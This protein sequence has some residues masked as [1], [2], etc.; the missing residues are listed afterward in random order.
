[1]SHKDLNVHRN[2]NACK[3]WGGEGIDLTCTG[4]RMNPALS[5][6]KRKGARILCIKGSSEP[7]KGRG[8]SLGLFHY[9]TDRNDVK[10]FNN[11]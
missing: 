10:P 11:Q 4:V 2:I 6:T 1:M 9:K 5:I 7:T 8:F 3:R